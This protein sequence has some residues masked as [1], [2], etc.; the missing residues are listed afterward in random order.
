MKNVKDQFVT[1]GAD[2]LERAVVDAPTYGC[3]PA[4]AQPDGDGSIPAK[5]E[6]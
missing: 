4:S 2:T 6:R 1:I 3:Q 5:P